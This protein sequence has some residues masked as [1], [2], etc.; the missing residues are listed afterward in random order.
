MAITRTEG[1]IT[2]QTFGEFVK[3]AWSIILVARKT[4]NLPHSGHEWLRK[5]P[6]FLPMG[7]YLWKRESKSNKAGFSLNKILS[8][9]CEKKF[10]LC[11]RE[12]EK[13]G[14]HEW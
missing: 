12:V 11:Y 4:R 2:P 7:N 10:L 8:I 3:R 13:G 5:G 6:G 1:K 9:K 14:N